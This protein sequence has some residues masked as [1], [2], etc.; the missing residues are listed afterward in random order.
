MKSQKLSRSQ[1]NS[2]LLAYSATAGAV[3]LVSSAAD[4][5]SLQLITT[6]PGN[7]YFANNSGGSDFTGVP[8]V[9]FHGTNGTQKFQQYRPGTPGR[10][11]LTTISSMGLHNTL[12]PGTAGRAGYFST[13]HIAHNG[14][15]L[16]SNAAGDGNNAY[17]LSK[18]APIAGGNFVGGQQILATQK[19]N[20]YGTT[21]HGNFVN[22]SG[23][24]AFKD[25]SYYGWLKIR[26]G[27][28]GGGAPD[29]LSFLSNGSG[30]FGAIDK[31][32]DPAG[33][34]FN[35]GTTAAPEPSGMTI[36]GLA[37]LALGARGVK[38]LRRRRQ[39]A[40]KL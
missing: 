9:R 38:E 22:A 3:V 27:K 2:K 26:V 29:S 5:G 18:G 33:D 28:D 19:P 8:H 36:G 35:V 34:G 37:L 40:K 21:Q 15:L 1:F 4:A 13:T 12:S 31:T 6:S 32:S 10:P 25:G 17:L 24:I 14:K 30:V 11:P 20:G 23:Y 16:V 39:V 7:F